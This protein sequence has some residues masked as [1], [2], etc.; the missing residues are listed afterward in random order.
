MGNFHCVPRLQ[1]ENLKNYVQRN[2]CPQRRKRKIDNLVKLA[3]CGDGQNFKKEAGLWNTAGIF[4]FSI[5]IF[6]S[7][8]SFYQSSGSREQEFDP[9]PILITHMK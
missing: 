3:A 5:F 2:L 8:N 6:F 9:F 4:F 1:G 7:L